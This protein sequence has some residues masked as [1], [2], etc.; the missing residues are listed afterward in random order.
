MI[1]SRKRD[2]T[3]FKI[4][5][6][7]CVCVSVIELQWSKESSVLIVIGKDKQCFRL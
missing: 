2:K 3:Y 4:V 5:F 1:I 6:C 7:V